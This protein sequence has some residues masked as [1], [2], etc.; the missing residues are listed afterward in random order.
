MAVKLSKRLRAIADLIPKGAVVAD[1]GCDHGYIPIYLLESGKSRYAIAMDVREGPLKRAEEHIAGHHLEGYIETRLSDGLR[2]LQ[3]GEA[4]TVVIAGMGGGLVKKILTESAH[5]R[6]SIMQYVLQPQS[7]I[8]SVRAFLR[9]QGLVIVAEDMVCE[10][11]KYYPMMLVRPAKNTGACE[12]MEGAAGQ[13]RLL[14]DTYGPLLLSQGHPV[15]KEY[16]LR[17]E[18]QLR[19]VLLSLEQ[20]LNS[21]R[22]NARMQEMKADLERN[23]RAQEV[24]GKYGTEDI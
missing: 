24:W 1:V 6:D 11:E 3:P 23:R 12:D 15:L 2:Q 4:D 21:E 20:S 9:E 22:R 10:D 7:E 8:G 16:L 13:D 5:V 19:T 18:K 14:A 17:E